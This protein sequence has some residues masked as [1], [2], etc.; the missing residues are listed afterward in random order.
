M[1]CEANSIADAL[2]N[3]SCDKGNDLIVY[4]NCPILVILKKYIYKL[5]LYYLDI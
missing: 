1:Y 2:G 4:D 3:L 5:V